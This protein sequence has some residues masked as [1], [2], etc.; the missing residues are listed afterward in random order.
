MNRVDIELELDPVVGRSDG[1]ANRVQLT[2][3]QELLD[4]ND[5]DSENVSLVSF[6][7]QCKTL[8][9]DEY[10][11]IDLLQGHEIV[12]D[13]KPTKM[14]CASGSMSTVLL[15]GSN[16]NMGNAQFPKDTM[17][18][19]GDLRLRVRYFVT[20][21]SLGRIRL[22]LSFDKGVGSGPSGDGAPRRMMQALGHDLLTQ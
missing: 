18:V 13:L 12:G 19:P 21:T 10:M 1:K 5:I 2:G 9:H 8:G 20:R 4:V 22:L 17:V 14:H 15:S 16:C 11:S 6:T 7:V 3:L